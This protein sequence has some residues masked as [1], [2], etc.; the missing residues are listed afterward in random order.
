MKIQIFVDFPVQS[1]INTPT[2]GGGSFPV[3]FHAIACK[4]GSIS[5]PATTAV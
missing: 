2:F 4:D 3:R 5:T 1:T